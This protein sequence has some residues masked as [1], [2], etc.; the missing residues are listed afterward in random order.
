MFSFNNLVDT[1]NTCVGTIFSLATRCEAFTVIPG[2]HQHVL[3]GLISS[4]KKREQ[5]LQRKKMEQ[6]R[7]SNCAIQNCILILVIASIC[8]YF[9]LYEIAVSAILVLCIYWYSM[10]NVIYPPPPELSATDYLQMFNTV[11]NNLQQKCE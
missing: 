1:A 5:I 8:A 2:P 11:G 9:A 7:A 10:K 3:Q 6:E 4:A